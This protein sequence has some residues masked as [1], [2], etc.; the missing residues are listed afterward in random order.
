MNNMEKEHSKWFK[1]IQKKQA[2]LLGMDM[3]K[4]EL[5]NSFDKRCEEIKS[6][7]RDNRQPLS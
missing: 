7:L 5:E 3:Q 4:R 2:D 1:K 6:Y